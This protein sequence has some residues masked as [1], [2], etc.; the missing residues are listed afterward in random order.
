MPDVKISALPSAT[1]P[2]AGTE[3][4]PIVQSGTTKQVSISDLTAGRSISCASG[5]VSANSAGDALRITQTGAGNAL[6]VEDSANPDSTPFVVTAAGDV[7]I[8]TGSPAYKL[9]VRGSDTPLNLYGNAAD[10]RLMVDFPDYDRVEINARNK[11]DN[12]SRNIVFQTDGGNVGIG[13][14]SAVYASGER[15]SVYNASG[16]N[17]IGVAVGNTNNVGIGIYNGYTSTGT[18]TAVEFQDHNSIIRGSI[19]VTTSA[20][21]YNTSSDY[22]LKNITGPV[23]NSGT[24]ID[25]LNPVEGTWKVDGSTFVGLIAHEVQEAS[26]TQIVVGEKD[27]EKMQGMDY[28][29]A[30]IIANLIAEVK[31]LRARVATLEAGNP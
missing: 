28:S 13:L 12:A 21:A 5:V 23:T 8:G 19:T 16:G 30:E 14:A 2:L 27:G 29:S 7:G 22:R 6:V 10:I 20:T 25:S 11:I 4:L 24:Y 15:L 18:A 31:S 26:R 17:G 1:T 3:V 9:D